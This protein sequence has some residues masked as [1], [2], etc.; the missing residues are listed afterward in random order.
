MAVGDA[1]MEHIE[2]IVID[3]VN[4]YYAMDAR[5][6]SQDFKHLHIRVEG[7]WNNSSGATYPYIFFGEG[8]SVNSSAVYN[9]GTHNGYMNNGTAQGGYGDTGATLGY[10][11]EGLPNTSHS[12]NFTGVVHGDLINYSNSSVHSSLHYSSWFVE[13]T[14]S[15][16]WRFTR[17]WV[18]YKVASAVNV[19]FVQATSGSTYWQVGSRLDIWGYNN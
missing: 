8:G 12:A 15:T 13:D 7:R 6:V 11:G 19:V 2:S 3:D 18:N 16:Y 10:L 5:A 9:R 17:G 4:T 1:G 14:A